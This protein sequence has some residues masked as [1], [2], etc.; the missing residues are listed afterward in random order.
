MFLKEM[1]KIVVKDNLICSMCEV[2]LKIFELWN[3]VSEEDR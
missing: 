1:W 3:I 2:N